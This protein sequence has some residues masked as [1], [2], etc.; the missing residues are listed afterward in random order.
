MLDA[1][2]AAKI[3]A[4]VSIEL[5]PPA[6]AGSSLRE[7][8]LNPGRPGT[9]ILGNFAD[10]RPSPVDAHF[11]AS[12][13][14]RN[15]ECEA[16]TDLGSRQGAVATL[17]MT[18][19]TT[20]YRVVGGDAGAEPN[21]APTEATPNLGNDQ[22]GEQNRLPL[23]SVGGQERTSIGEARGGAAAIGPQRLSAFTAVSPAV[24][25]VS[26][27]SPPAG[28]PVPRPSSTPIVDSTV[29]PQ[30]SPACIGPVAGSKSECHPRLCRM[31]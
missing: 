30:L 23:T 18:G 11:R 27:P 15:P 17:H 19:D 26:L 31:E 4:R 8:C 20:T 6:S 21:V 5:L 12:L 22:T 13:K 16:R 1:A 3:S 29:C 25:A 10:A 7:R 9:R 14:E 2:V 28:S 24:S